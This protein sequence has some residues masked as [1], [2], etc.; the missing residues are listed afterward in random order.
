MKEVIKIGK[1]LKGGIVQFEN[2]VAY[3]TNDRRTVAIKI[4]N[5]KDMGTGTV[6]PEEIPT[7]ATDIQRRDD[8]V[9]FS[10][11]EAN[12]IRRISVPEKLKIAEDCERVLSELFKEPILP[13]PPNLLDSID[14]NILVTRLKLEGNKLYSNQKRS[15]G[16]VEFSNVFYLYRGRGLVKEPIDYPETDEVSVLTSDLL[17]L[18]VI[19]EPKIY[20]GKSDEVLSFVGK[21]KTGAEVM[22]LISYLIYEV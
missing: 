14:K 15:D 9:W 3:L 6:H 12:S 20:L 16:T 13:L 5:S 4:V 18:S 11:K 7:S 2:N 8:R 22:G 1:M 17:V 21:T 19:E 10:W